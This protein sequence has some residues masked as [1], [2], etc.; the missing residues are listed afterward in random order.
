MRKII[1]LM[2]VF[3]LIFGGCANS[4]QITDDMQLTGMLVDGIR[5]IEFEAYRY[6]WN[7]PV[8]TVR[9]GERVKI[10]AKSR[11]VAHGIAIPAVEFN[12]QIFPNQVTIGE[13][14]APAQGE[15]AYGCSVMCGPGHH[16]HRGK[17]VV[18]ANE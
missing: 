6:D 18:I 12:L 13:F 7:E 1:L 16:N 2:T 4:K 14:T 11:D 17:L 10:I 15:Y 5:E 8:I 3:L 9:E